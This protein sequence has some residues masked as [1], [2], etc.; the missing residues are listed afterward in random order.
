MGCFYFGIVVTGLEATRRYAGAATLSARL[1][2]SLRRS[3]CRYRCEMR[4]PTK[5]AMHSELKPA[6]RSE[7]K[8][9]MVPA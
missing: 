2:P 1:M 8:P 9:A 7:L 4:I 6:T 5:P 3:I